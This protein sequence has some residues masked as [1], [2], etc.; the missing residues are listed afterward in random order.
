MTPPQQTARILPLRFSATSNESPDPPPPPTEAL[1][2]PKE[3]K[4]FDEFYNRV[5]NHYKRLDLMG[6]TYGPAFPHGR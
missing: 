2:S 6:V 3:G 4:N 5:E 1:W